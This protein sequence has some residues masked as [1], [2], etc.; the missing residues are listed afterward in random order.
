MTDRI[1]NEQGTRFLDPRRMTGR[2]LRELG[3]SKLAYVKAV[4]HDGEDV[5]AIHAADGTP[6]A[7]ADDFHSAVEAII[8]HELIPAWVH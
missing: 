7:L 5:F 8:E 3:V 6:M 2:E 1:Q 4:I